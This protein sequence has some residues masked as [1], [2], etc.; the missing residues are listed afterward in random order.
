[1]V[2]GAPGRAHIRQEGGCWPARRDVGTGPKG[3]RPGVTEDWSLPAGIRW[4]AVGILRSD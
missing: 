4:E 3:N 1:M 2:G